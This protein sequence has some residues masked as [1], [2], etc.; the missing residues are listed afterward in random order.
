MHKLINLNIDYTLKV[1]SKVKNFYDPDYIYV[2]IFDDVLLN[3]NENDN[4]LK[5]QILL[6]GVNKNYASSISGKVNGVS[7]VTINGKPYKALKIANDFKEKNIKEKIKINNIKEI[8][9]IDLIYTLDQLNLKN[10]KNKIN[11][12]AKYLIVNG[13]TDE[14]FIYNEQMYLK[15]YSEEILDTM[16][17]LKKI[18]SIDNLFVTL[19]SIY[20]NNIESFLFLMGQYPEIHLLLFDDLYLLEKDY[21][22]LEKLNIKKEDCIILKPKEIYEIYNI[23][24][25]N[26][27]V[28]EKYV[29]ISGNGINKNVVINA[30]IY[31]SLNEILKSFKIDNN[32]DYILNGLMTGK[33]IDPTTEI[34]TDD[35]EGLLIM[36]KQCIN[37]NKCINC[38]KCYEI[39]PIKVNPK[40]SLLNNKINKNCLDCGLCSYVCPSH[41]NLRKY[42]KGDK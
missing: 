9:K 25:Y 31:S 10:L 5:N 40:I 17:F 42:L 24:K 21:F 33:E 8:N 39:C 4:V 6:E 11:K 23:L 34:I 2:P 36:K 26:K 38:G 19:K 22:L 7:N 3:I 16:D 1:S 29:T 13:I 20:Q 30:K 14:P 27:F 32:V 37:E 18:L 12:K 28:D 35:T 41:I 15:N